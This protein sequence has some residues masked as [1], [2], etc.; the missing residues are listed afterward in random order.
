[1]EPHLVRARLR[2][3]RFLLALLSMCAALTTLTGVSR[4][5]G[6]PIKHSTGG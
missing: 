1:M 5:E 6:E 2:P 3:V 4:A